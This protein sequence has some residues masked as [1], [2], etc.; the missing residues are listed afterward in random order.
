MFPSNSGNLAVALG[1]T[2]M[3]LWVAKMPGVWV[4]KNRM[5][6]PEYRLAVICRDPPFIDARINCFQGFGVGSGHS[7]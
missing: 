7:Y 6:P 1:S 3:K 5:D 2:R 4:Q